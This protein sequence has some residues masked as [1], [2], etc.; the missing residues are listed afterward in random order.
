MKGLPY[1]HYFEW[2]DDRVY[3]SE[4]TWKIYQRALGIEI[5]SLAPLRSFDLSNEA[6][7]AELNRYYHDKVPLDEKIISPKA[8]FES[9][10]LELVQQ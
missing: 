5:G 8:M 2:T 3:C 4:L 1:D 9:E 10:L 7:K 6:V